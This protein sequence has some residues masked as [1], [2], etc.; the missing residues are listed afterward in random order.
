MS[1]L[2]GAG[3]FA[4]LGIVLVNKFSSAI[5]YF[6]EPKRIQKLA[7]ANAEAARI[8]SLA[9]C[10]SKIEHANADAVA[11]EIEVRSNAEIEAFRKNFTSIDN[12]LAE[13]A[14]RRMVCEEVKKQINLENILAQTIPLLKETSNP[15]KLDDDWIMKYSNE[16]RNISDSEMQKIWAK[17]LA[18]EANNPG[19]TNKKTLSILSS[20]SKADAELF[21]KLASIFIDFTGTKKILFEDLAEKLIGPNYF[22]LALKLVDI[23][24][25]SHSSLGLGLTLPV[26]AIG[27]PLEIQYDGKKYHLRLKTNRINM[28]AFRLTSSGYDL[29]DICNKQA[30]DSFIETFKNTR[31][32]TEHFDLI[33]KIK[34]ISV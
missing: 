7:L 5:G 2:T 20:M 19:A 21:E 22:D 10:N 32:Y 8:K 12:E 13:I 11:K 1:D 17:L 3:K 30:I 6:T 18:D 24:L 25:F 26:E 4:E 14:I 27:K 15:N 31:S 33:T 29:F 34:I 28:G 23:G 16:A 9:D